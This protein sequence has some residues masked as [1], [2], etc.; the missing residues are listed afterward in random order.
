MCIS[1][2]QCSQA[3]LPSRHFCTLFQ[4]AFHRTGQAGEVAVAYMPAQVRHLEDGFRV[5][6]RRVCAYQLAGPR[7]LRGSAAHTQPAKRLALV[8]I[9]PSSHVA[10][11][12]RAVELA[13]A[14]VGGRAW[15]C[16]RWVYDL[17]R[18]DVP[19]GEECFTRGLVGEGAGAWERPSAAAERPRHVS[20]HRSE[21]GVPQWLHRM[22]RR[23]T[24]GGLAGWLTD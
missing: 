2:G 16:E 3:L 7:A 14:G 4:A 12:I 19:C 1:R 8:P 17:T 21:G 20:V 15:V 10:S 11:P 23:Q 6:M 18:S 9:V 13:C 5:S 22:C 24:P